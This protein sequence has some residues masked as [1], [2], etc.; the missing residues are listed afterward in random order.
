MN[1]SD[2][3]V[4]LSFDIPSDLSDSERV[5]G[6]ISILEKLKTEHEPKLKSAL[7]QG[8]QQLLHGNTL[9]STTVPRL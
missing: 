7:I 8:A 4:L 1:L 9:V 5:M 2:A 6:V 3:Q